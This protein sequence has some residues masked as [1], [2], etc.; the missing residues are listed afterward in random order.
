MIKKHILF[1]LTTFFLS[2]IAHANLEIKAR[3]AI[4]QDFLSGEILY[5]K[6]PDRSIYPA[7]MTKIMTSIIAFDLIKS[8]DLS[9]E[10]KFIISEKA[11]RLSTAGYSSM[12]VMIGD[13][14][15]V[16]DLLKGIIVAS[17]NDACIALAEGIAGTEEEFAIMMTS[18]AKEIGMDNTNFANSSGINDPD[19]YSTVRD[20]MIMSNYLIKNHP[21]YYEW[22]SEKEFTWDRTGGDPIT[23]GNRNPLLYKNMG[24]DGIKTGYLAVERYSL[25]S[26]ILKKGRRL[27]AVGSGFETKNERSKQSAKLLTYG[28]TNFDLVEVSKKDKDFTSVEVWLGKEKFVKVH[29]EEDIYKTI[30]KGQKKRLKIKVIYNGPIEAPIKKNESLAKLKI[31]YDEDLIGEYD[32]LASNSVKKVNIFSR[33]LKSINYLIW[34]DV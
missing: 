12:F 29:T 8:G 28:L 33:L 31:I 18:K 19:N 22:F 32:L 7:S 11:W 16:E 15:S 2:H 1:I 14:V 5:E 17:G 30:K 21:E 9:L 23:Q 27:I 20:I 13:E 10:E 26:S 24:A 34:G 25:A 4:L 6:E 3:T